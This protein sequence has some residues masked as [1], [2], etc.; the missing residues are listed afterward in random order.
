MESEARTRMPSI[1]ARDAE[2]ARKTSVLTLGAFARPSK[3]MDRGFDNICLAENQEPDEQN[4][5][6][7]SGN[8]RNGLHRWVNQGRTE[9]IG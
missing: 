3:N 4:E 5:E 8:Y 9:E 2:F 7:Y 1:A 6:H